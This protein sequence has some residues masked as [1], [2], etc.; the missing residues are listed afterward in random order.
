MTDQAPRLP[1][2]VERAEVVARDVLRPNIDEEDRDALWPEPGMRALG[3]MGLLGLNAPTSV[4][5]H[6][7]GLE[8][9]AS[10]TRVLARE[11][12]SAALCFGMHCVGTAVIGAKATPAQRDALLTPIAQGSHITTLALSE[13]GTGSHFWFPETQIRPDGD[14]YV[15][16]GVKSFVTSGGRADSYVMSTV[17]A[18]EAADGDGVFSAVLVEAGSPGLEWQEEWRGFG[19]R[20]NASRSVRLEGVRIP[21]DHLL[22]E[23]G[24]QLWYVFEVVAPYFLIAMAGTYLGI[25]EAAVDIAAEHLGSRRHTHTGELLG[26]HPRLSAELGSMWI[27]LESAR[28]L[29]FSAAR[30][31]DAAAPDGLPGVLACKAAATRAAVDLTNRAMTLVGGLGYRENSHLSRLLR[32]ARAGHVMAPTTYVLEAWLGRAL[33]GM[34]LLS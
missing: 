24:D 7:L 17:A 2:L 26:S 13:P 6:G 33:L 8:A 11:N 10:I 31:A 9:L 4:G 21:R 19:M 28:Q 30:R 20:G 18:T 5:G 12:P 3:T 29:V 27:D 14:G 32:D 15:V 34:P 25:A 16:D 22:G 23:E 1:E